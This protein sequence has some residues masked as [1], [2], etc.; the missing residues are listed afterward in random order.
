MATLNLSPN[1]VPAPAIQHDWVRW[2][3][4]EVV[5]IVDPFTG[6][7]MAHDAPFSAVGEQVACRACGE[8]LTDS[9]ILVACTGEQE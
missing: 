5:V 6:V 9:S 4:V 7:P 2:S 1:S 3:L 8:P